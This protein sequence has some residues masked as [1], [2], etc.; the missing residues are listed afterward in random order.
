MYCPWRT[1]DVSHEQTPVPVVNTQGVLS[2][3]I[4]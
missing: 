1:S 2:A 4:L 3:G